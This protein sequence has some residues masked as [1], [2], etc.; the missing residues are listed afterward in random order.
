[1]R[2]CS[3]LAC[4]ALAACGG[5]GG[6]GFTQMPLTGTALRSASGVTE[7]AVVQM[8]GTLENAAG[9]AVITDGIYELIDSDGPDA[10]GTLRDES[11][12]LRLANA[13]SFVATYPN[14]TRFT[15]SYQTGGATYDLVGIAGPAPDPVSLSSSATVTYNGE[16]E[17]TIATAA[18][19]FDLTGGV[20]EVTARFGD[21]A[22]D[23][24]AFGFTTTDLLTGRTVANPIDRIAITDMALKNGAL[25]GGTIAATLDGTIVDLVGG[26]TTHET[27]GA[28]FGDNRAGTAPAAVGGVFVVQGD[29]GAA[30]GTFIAN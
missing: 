5:G 23:M 3:F 9:A 24:A 7:Y 19:G 11:S 27:A 2:Y 28:F 29:A 6:S 25:S 1:M 4:L 15:Q 17:I 10:N 18:E 20:S 12:V 16:A 13:P 30:I 8:S 26:A 14:A 22:V 21:D